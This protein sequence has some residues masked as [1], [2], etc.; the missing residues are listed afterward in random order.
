[1]PR[2]NLFVRVVLSPAIECS[3][4]QENPGIQG[5]FPWPNS[6]TA[7]NLFEGVRVVRSLAIERLRREVTLPTKRDFSLSECPLGLGQKLNTITA[8]AE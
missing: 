5:A 6:R 1:M 2:T 7:S 8:S 4:G 3:Q